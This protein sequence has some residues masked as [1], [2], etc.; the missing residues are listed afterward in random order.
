MS[1]TEDWES[2]SH[3]GP[4]GKG[5]GMSEREIVKIHVAVVGFT[6]EGDVKLALPKKF[7]NDNGGRRVFAESRAAIE[8][9]KTRFVK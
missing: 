5:G 6:G 2:R 9:A 3:S 1:G 7:Y 8:A 4:D